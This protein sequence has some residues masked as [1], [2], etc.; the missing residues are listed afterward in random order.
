MSKE[1][2]FG[3]CNW[4]MAGIA[5]IICFMVFR[6]LFST[7]S[8]TRY[9]PFGPPRRV[10]QKAAPSRPVIQNPSEAP[11]GSIALPAKSAIEPPKAPK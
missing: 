3:I 5:L 4:L 8:Q 2:I 11:G 7:P 10:E 9:D 6:D 1:T